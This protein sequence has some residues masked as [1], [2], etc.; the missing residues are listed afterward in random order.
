MFL[1]EM[2]AGPLGGHMT[3]AIRTVEEQQAYRLH[4]PRLHHS[5][6]KLDSSHYLIYKREE[7]CAY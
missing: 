6:R 4:L 3:P 7:E 1:S 2:G 5:L